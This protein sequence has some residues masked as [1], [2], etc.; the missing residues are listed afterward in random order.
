MKFHEHVKTT[1]I[2]SMVLLVT[3]IV[4][5]IGC[6]SNGK[7]DTSVLQE[8]TGF[9]QIPGVGWQTFSRTADEDHSLKTYNFKSGCA[10]YRFYWI[11]LEP[12]EGQFAFD[13]IDDILQHCLQNNQ[14]LAFRVMCENPWGEGLPQWLIDKGIKRTFSPCPEEGA[15]YV[16]DMSDSIFSYYHQRLI[17]SL[18]ERY[19]DHPDLALVDIGSVGL[20][21]EWHIFCDSS[22]MPNRAIRQAVTD[23][24]FQ[25]FPNTPLT[26]L[27]GD[28]TNCDYARG[29]GNCGWRG[30]S[31][32]D[33]DSTG[34]R[35]NDHQFYYWPAHNR[36]PNAWKTGT[37]A[38]EPGM[39]EG[40]M[41]GWTAPVKNIVDN[42]ITWH[43]TFAQNKSKNIP[44]AF[45]PEIERLIMKLGF[46]LVLRNL[47]YKN[48]AV[49]GSEIP[50]SMKWENIGIAPPYRD[51]RI[52]FRL[53]SKNDVN[54]A[55][56][57]TD[58]SIKGWLPG[59]TSITVNYKV[60]VDLQTG[61]YS[62]EMGLVFHSSIEHTIPIANKGKTA[63]GWYT[64]GSMKI[65]H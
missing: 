31:W 48:E 13:M 40:T 57:I 34:G 43:A 52:A 20:W 25:S 4:F 33:A 41:N 46:R 3:V 44:A 45:I 37:V 62:L 29:K 59:E 60:P 17:R 39:P 15:H 26:A 32:G 51:H 55:T 56:V 27:V 54:N 24:Y 63:D 64:I 2:K 11:S 42:T 50:I 58:Q 38:L 35:W 65:T 22:L 53:K 5:I 47:F 23:L 9:L 6:S 7:P 49:S 36:L 30:D 10:Y 18:G 28:E 8:D 12:Q 14:A 21:G 19:D 16:P 1:M 61:N